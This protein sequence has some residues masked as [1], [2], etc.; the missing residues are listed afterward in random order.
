MHV[1]RAGFRLLDVF[2]TSLF[3]GNPLA[4]FRQS[5][6]IPA[7]YLQAVARELNLSECAFAHPMAGRHGEWRL[8]I[9]T[10]TMEHAF[11]GHPTIGA[12]LALTE[13]WDLEDGPVRIVLHEGIGPVP[14]TVERAE[15]GVVARL[16][17]PVSPEERPSCDPRTLAAML[18]LDEEDI[19][20]GPYRP[21]A[22]ACGVPFQIVPLTTLDALRRAR[23]RRDLWERDLARTWAPHLYLVVHTPEADDADFRVR[24]FAPLMGVDEDPATGGAAAALTGLLAGTEPADGRRSWRIRQGVEMDRPSLLELG[25]EVRS[26]TA[27]AITVGGSAVFTGGGHIDLPV[28]VSG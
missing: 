11:A 18:S 9:F 25:A 2:T 15:G 26:G 4:V 16:T 12:A 27:S 1:I 20:C 19:G 28:D 17:V 13:G 22:L 21:R 6:Q 23:L 8:R 3:G 5:E 24:M 14:V 10:P 7:G